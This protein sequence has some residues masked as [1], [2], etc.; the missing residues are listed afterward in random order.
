MAIKFGEGLLK[1]LMP[2]TSII[3][4]IHASYQASEGISGDKINKL[5]TLLV[6]VASVSM[7]E[8]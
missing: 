7:E 4:N 2:A 8:C 6:E 3:E 1:K 5:N